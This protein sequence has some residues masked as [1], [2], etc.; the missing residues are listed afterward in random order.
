MNWPR[1][2]HLKLE[3]LIRRTILHTLIHQGQ[4]SLSNT[5]ARKIPLVYK[6]D[7]FWPQTHRRQSIFDVWTYVLRV[8]LGTCRCKLTRK[9]R[10]SCN[11]HNGGVVTTLLIRTSISRTLNGNTEKKKKK[12]PKIDIRVSHYLILAFISSN[13]LRTSGRSFCNS[14]SRHKSWGLCERQIVQSIIEIFNLCNI[15][16]Y[17]WQNKKSLRRSRVLLPKNIVIIYSTHILI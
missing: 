7:T 13:R 5:I 4:T 16:H 10:L 8:I 2:L 15:I 3:T 1:T 17:R 11:G 12:P 6:N 9:D 14:D